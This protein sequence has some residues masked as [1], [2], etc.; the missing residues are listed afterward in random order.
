MS[1]DAGRS[2]TPLR[3][4]AL[5]A[6]R[7][8]DLETDDRWPGVAYVA[9]DDGVYVF[10]GAGLPLCHDARR[11]VDETIVWPGEC[12]PILSPGPVRL[13]DTIAVAGDMVRPAPDRVDLGAVNC[14]IEDADIAFA[15]VDP[16]DPP[17]GE[18][19][20]ILSREEGTDAYG[21]SSDGLPRLAT[22][23][24]CR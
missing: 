8:Y 15:T 19:L 24:D 14:L 16:P 17:P 9:T 10:F 11:G 3:G 6:R 18:V 4:D 12:P 22:S 5:R 2:W 1:R 20:L 7:L 13:G 23:G 21:R